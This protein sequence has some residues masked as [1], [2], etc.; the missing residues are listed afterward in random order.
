[1]DAVAPDN[2]AQRHGHTVASKRPHHAWRDR[3]V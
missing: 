2:L 1:M 3:R